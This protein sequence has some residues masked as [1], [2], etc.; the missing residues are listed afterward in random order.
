MSIGGL[1]SRGVSKGLVEEMHLS[2]GLKAE[3]PAIQGGRKN[4]QEDGTV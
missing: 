1:I 4:I 2:Q 3:E